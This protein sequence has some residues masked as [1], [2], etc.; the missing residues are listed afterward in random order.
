MFGPLRLTIITLAILPCSFRLTSNEQYFELAAACQREKDAWLDSIR[1]AMAQPSIWSNEPSPSYRL[2]GKAFGFP[3][4]EDGHNDVANGL[5]TIRSIA[6]F[7]AASD[8]DFSEPF[9]ASLRGNSKSRRRRADTPPTQRQEAPQGPSR[10]SSSNSVKAIFSPMSSDAE[11]VVVRRS[12]AAARLQ[13][14][15]ELQDVISRTCITARSYAFTHEEQLF[16]SPKD[17]FSRSNSTTM[18]GMSRLSKH[19]SVRIPRR[20]TDDPSRFSPYNKNPKNLQVRLSG[21]LLEDVDSISPVPSPPPTTGAVSVQ[22]SASSTAS[23]PPAPSSPHVFESAPVKSRS[24][25][26]NVRELFH[27]RPVSPNPS[28]HQASLYSNQHLAPGSR[29]R[30]DTHRR[31]PRSTYDELVGETGAFDVLEKSYAV[32]SS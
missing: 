12:S 16:Q 3:G 18:V 26:R 20:R 1:E 10:R 13:V 27:F 21:A 17:V 22:S 15:Q 5:P 32:P 23:L 19:E 14:D 29:W 24:F 30:W 8:T 25:V 2:G 6:E 11:T 7:G 4:S 9:L 28:H 31:R